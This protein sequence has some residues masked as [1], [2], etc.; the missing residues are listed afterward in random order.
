MKK[1]NMINSVESL[2]Y[3]KCYSWGSPWLVKSIVRKDVSTLISKLSPSITRIL[4]FLKTPHRPKISDSK[5]KHIGVLKIY[6]RVTGY[7]N[8]QKIQKIL[9]KQGA[10][11]QNILHWKV[12]SLLYVNCAWFCSHKH[13]IECSSSI[14][15]DFTDQ[16]I[17]YDFLLEETQQTQQNKLLWNFLTKNIL[18]PCFN[19]KIWY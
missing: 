1:T 5:T 15:C 8:C 17:A 11:R 14:V 2:G 12:G 6:W 9:Q 13:K 7:Q 10:V 18:M 19:K 3:I 4:P 16:Y